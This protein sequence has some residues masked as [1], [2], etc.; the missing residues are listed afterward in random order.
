MV[1]E[2]GSNICCLLI[3]SSSFSLP[4]MGQLCFSAF[5]SLPSAPGGCHIISFPTQDVKSEAHR[6][7]MRH[8]NPCCCHR[9]RFQGMEA[10]DSSS[11]TTL[12]VCLWTWHSCSVSEACSNHHSKSLLF[13]SQQ[14]MSVCLQALGE[15]DQTVDCYT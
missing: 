15:T 4:N 7:L 8:T 9:N 2:R 6:S 12:S 14:N 1:S 10:G 11:Q 3:S 5:K 13:H